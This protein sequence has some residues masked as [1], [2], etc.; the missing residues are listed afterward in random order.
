MK[1]K[2]TR[3]PNLHTSNPKLL[4]KL[5]LDVSS[6][7]MGAVLSQML[8]DKCEHPIAYACRAL[9]KHEKMYSQ[10]DKQGVDILFKIKF[11]QYIYGKHITL[12]IYCK[13]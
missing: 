13:P 2:L 5:T 8:R 11:H 7:G 10:L 1:L 6:Q 9:N 4:L 3:P 12:S